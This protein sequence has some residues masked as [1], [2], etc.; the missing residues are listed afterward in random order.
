M[1]E[2]A[3]GEDENAGD[4]FPFFPSLLTCV[5][6]IRLEGVTFLLLTKKC[7]EIRKIRQ[8]ILYGNFY[9]TIAII[10]ELQTWSYSKTK[11]LHKTI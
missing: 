8:K 6:V 5:G 2:D 7:L 9:P 10:L 4:T 3:N 1:P 11:Y